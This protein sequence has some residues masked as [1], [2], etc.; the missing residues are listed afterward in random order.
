MLDSS[1]PPRSSG[2]RT[3][4]IRMLL[5]AATLVLASSAAQPALAHVGIEPGGSTPTGGKSSTIYLRPGHGCEG[6]ATNAFT[7]TVPDGVT[8][9]KGQQKAGWSLVAD[10]NVLRWSGGTLPDDQWDTFGIRLT[11]PKLAEGV[12]S[13]TF[14]FKAVQTCDAELEIARSGKRATVTGRLPAFAGRGVSLKVD[15]IPLTVREQVIGA[16]GSFAVQ[17]I[18]AK[19][20]YDRDVTAWIDGRVVANSI[21]RSQAWV[22]TAPGAVMPAPTVTVIRG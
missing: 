14:A 10:G 15:G 13:Q 18:S 7:V 5:A 8:G 17:T 1:T 19:V 21:A 6:D 16:D 4:T 3:R 12:N 20:P 22:D 11:W 9:V 2:A